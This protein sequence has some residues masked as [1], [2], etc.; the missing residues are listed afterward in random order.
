[1]GGIILI[2]E[3]STQEE[4]ISELNN[5]R[6]QIQ[7]LKANN[8]Q[9]K[10]QS[11][12]NSPDKTKFKNLI[13]MGNEI[14]PGILSKEFLTLS[15]VTDITERKLLER[16]LL[17]STERYRDMFENSPGAI[18]LA[19]PDGTILDVNPAGCR[20]FGWAKEEICTIGR[21][22]V[23]DMNDIRT[24]NAIKDR[25]ETGRSHSELTF[26]RK[27]GTRFQGE[28]TSNL[29]K[30]VDGQILTSIFI[31]NISKRKQAEE[32]LRQSE[33]KFS[34]V[35]HGGPIMMLIATIEEGEILDAN[36]ALCSITGYTR[37]EIIGRTTSEIIF[38]QEI[39]NRQERVKILR[40]LGRVGNG[41]EEIYFQTKSGEMR[42]CVFWCQEIILDGEPCHIAG[43][44]DVTEKNHIQTEMAKLDRL[45]LVGQLAA[46][47]AHEIRNPMTTVRGFL[48]LFK[49]RYND[50]ND[51][52]FFNLMIEELDRA[53][54]IITEFLSI[55]NNKIVKLIPKNLNLIVETILPLIQTSATIQQKEIKLELRDV[56]DI[57]LDEKEMRQLIL[58][59]VNNG[60][61]SMS[62]GGYIT[63]RTFIEEETVVL[64]IQDNG[65]GIAPEILDKVGTPF[66]TNKE[67]GTGLGLAV[68]YGIAIRHNAKIDIDTSSTGTTFFIRFPIQIGV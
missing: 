52:S 6:Q 42:Q 51:I 57:L 17:H 67:Q 23:L 3:S 68:C 63:I 47:I 13:T 54:T 10:Q 32:T 34:K 44:S 19:Q 33:E 65:K 43:I 20:L 58:N 25:T 7:E 14:R 12:N 9:Y 46:S 45:N 36:E 18:L 30:S 50:D 5:L 48:Q 15:S 28:T 22:G 29:F 11:N 64:S 61:E 60:L 26:I 31:R 1:L 2:Y 41:N 35:F 21:S 40:V 49:A 56:P 66:V 55:A 53:N 38:P 8:S 27:D 39:Y 59:T 16:N 4:L 37:E 24:F 62:E